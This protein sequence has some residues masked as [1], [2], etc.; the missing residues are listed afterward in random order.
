MGILSKLFSVGD[1]SSTVEAV[2]KGL[3]S[4]FT[5][6][7]ER[8][9]KQAILTRLAQKPA[10][11]QVELNKVEAGHRSLFVAGWR[12]F[13]GW[14]C[15]IGLAFTFVVNPTLQWLTGDTGPAVPSDVMMELVIAMLGLGGLRT[16]EK[17]KGRAK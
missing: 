2:G 13:L 6:D 9:D 17:M 1:A 4:L 7:E 11:M 8:L 12:P 14:V 16:I 5:S 15:G 3:D 10:A